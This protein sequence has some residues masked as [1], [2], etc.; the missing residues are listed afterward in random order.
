MAPKTSSKVIDEDL[1]KLLDERI[2]GGK[3]ADLTEQM[4]IAQQ[5]SER[6]VAWIKRIG[7]DSDKE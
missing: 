3:D 4:K 2:S 5:N 7:Q 1:S 6:M